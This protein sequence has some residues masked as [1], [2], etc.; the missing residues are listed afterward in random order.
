M[1]LAWQNRWTVIDIGCVARV[2]EEAPLSFTLAYAAPEVVEA[3]R[4]H[5]GG[6]G[7]SSRRG[8][9]WTHVRWG[10][11]LW[12]AD[13]GAR[14][15]PVVSRPR[16]GVPPFLTLQRKQLLEACDELNCHLDGIDPGEPSSNDHVSD[17]AVYNGHAWIALYRCKPFLWHAGSVIVDQDC[18]ELP[19][20]L[21]LHFGDDAVNVPLHT[22]TSCGHHG[23]S[24]PR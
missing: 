14:I 12:A 9:R 24:E 22:T 1:W 7:R 21:H 23:A 10:D 8:R 20:N 2:G 16:A 5:R 11:R 17:Y 3:V 19:L 18:P 6:G 13:W 15:W 4:P